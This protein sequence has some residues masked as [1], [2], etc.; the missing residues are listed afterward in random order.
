MRN[1]LLASAA[2]LLGMGALC[3]GARAQTPS[4]VNANPANANPANAKPGGQAQA[5]GQAQ[6]PDLSGDWG[7][8]VAAGRGG[9]IIGD[10]GDPKAGTPED[11]TPYQPWA[12]AKLNS[13]RPEN[14]PHPTFEHTT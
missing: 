7:H 14:G 8:P 2:V 12:L 1:R 6:L 10:P 4:Q 9:F 3:A 13:E 11:T 5:Q